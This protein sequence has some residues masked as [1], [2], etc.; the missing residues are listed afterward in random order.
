MIPHFRIK[1][2]KPTESKRSGQIPGG[3]G[4][5]AIQHP[6]GQIRHFGPQ[7]GADRLIML[8]GGGNRVQG[9]GHLHLGIG[10]TIFA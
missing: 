8:L 4:T 10:G 1:S 7:E 6:I 5:E 9:V 2:Y 3:S